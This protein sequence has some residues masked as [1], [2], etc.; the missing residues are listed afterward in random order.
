MRFI[1]KSDILLEIRHVWLWCKFDVA[2]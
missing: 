2:V 1:D